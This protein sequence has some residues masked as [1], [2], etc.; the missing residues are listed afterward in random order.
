MDN[1]LTVRDICARYKC[2]ATT[3]RK[4]MRGMEHMES[5]LMVTERAVIAWEHKKTVPPESAVRQMMKG[6]L[7]NAQDI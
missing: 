2:T 1:I 3:A 5:P 4:R 6:R 7:H